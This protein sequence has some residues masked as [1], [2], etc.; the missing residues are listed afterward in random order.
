MF[1][2]DAIYCFRDISRY[3]TLNP[4]HNMASD[5]F[6]D[7]LPITGQHRQRITLIIHEVLHHLRKKL[8]RQTKT[9]ILLPPHPN[10]LPLPLHL[11]NLLGYCPN[12]LDY[13]QIILDS[14]QNPLDILFT[15]LRLPWISFKISYF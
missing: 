13:I 1:P 14:L 12:I 4:A 3:K 5:I 9:N 15:S 2:N 8:K 6:L 11:Q 7:H 10:P